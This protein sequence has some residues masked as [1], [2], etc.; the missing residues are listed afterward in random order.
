MMAGSS[1]CSAHLHHANAKPCCTIAG[2]WC[3]H[4]CARTQVPIEAGN[5][6]VDVCE[7]LL[8]LLLFVMRMHDGLGGAAADWHIPSGTPVSELATAGAATATAAAAAA[9]ARAMP[10][11]MACLVPSVRTGWSWN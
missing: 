1:A 2:L 7:I 11:W 3:A 10:W 5:F 8:L 4:F 6:A 9:A